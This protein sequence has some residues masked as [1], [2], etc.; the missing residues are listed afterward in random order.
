MI[1]KGSGGQKGGGRHGFKKEKPEFDQQIIDLARVT[2]VTKGG[3]HLSF[4]ATVLIGDRKGR[5]GFGIDKGKDVQI[6]VEKAANQAKKNVIT[7]PTVRQTIPHTVM[8]KYKSAKIIL[9]PAP[10]GSGIIAGGAVRSVL[11]MAGIPNASA[12]ILSRA[13]NKMNNIKATF[14]A[15][16]SF[17]LSERKAKKDIHEE[18]ADAEVKATDNTV[19]T[20]AD[21]AAPSTE[22]DTLKKKAK[23][24]VMFKKGPI[25]K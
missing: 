21:D 4:R 13:K 1:M 12:K 23:P 22:V 20:K 17:K 25:R 18:M 16:Q 5:V 11:E 15:L 19:V 10:R 8:A 2:R 3:K 9:M 6:G 14:I 7:V 24:P